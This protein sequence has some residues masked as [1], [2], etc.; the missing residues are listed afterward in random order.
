MWI[1]RIAL[2]RP[3]TFVVLAMV[4][5]IL[6]PL[7]IVRTPTDILPEISIPVISVVWNYNGLSAEEMSTRIVF[8]VERSLTT[9]VNDIE[10][11]ESQSLNGIGIIKVF[12]HPGANVEMALAQVTASV[13]D[14]AQA[15]PAGRQPAARHQLQ[16]LERPDP[17][18]RAVGR[19]PV[20]AAAVRPRVQFHPHPACDG[21]GRLDPL[22][23]RRAPA[24][25][26]GGPRP[27]GAPGEGAHAGR[28]GRRDQRAEP[29]SARR[30]LEDRLARVRRGHQRAARARWTS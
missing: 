19:V 26:A 18:A 28:R 25:G 1:V 30:D 5:L 6:G 11:I 23:V 8:N 13:A 24:T 22:A 16:R 9:L 20:R 15:A 21:A 2:N 27:G 29:D 12:F 7:S 4:L 3:Y 14:A 17:A 10:H